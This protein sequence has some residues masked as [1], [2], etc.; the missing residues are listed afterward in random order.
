MAGNR[1]PRVDVFACWRSVAGRCNM[2]GHMQPLRQNVGTIGAASRP[3]DGFDI[4]EQ[5]FFSRSRIFGVQPARIQFGMAKI[6]VA[7][8]GIHKP[9]FAINHTRVE[10][11]QLD[12][13]LK[14]IVCYTFYRTLK[15]AKERVLGQG[16]IQPDSFDEIQ[17]K[18]QL[19]TFAGGKIG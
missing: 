19:G 10:P 18:R 5:E 12:P 1:Q 16:I 15:L 11:A 9:H 17:L 14:L 6:K 2:H 7:D 4:F 3:F 13:M 8:T